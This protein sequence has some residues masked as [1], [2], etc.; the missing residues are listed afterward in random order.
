MNLKQIIKRKISPRGKNQDREGDTSRSRIQNVDTINENLTKKEKIWFKRYIIPFLK[1]ENKTELVMPFKKLNPIEKNF[2]EFKKKNYQESYPVFKDLFPIIIHP[3]TLLMAFTKLLKNNVRVSVGIDIK[4]VDDYSI[5]KLINLHQRLKASSYKPQFKKKEWIPQIGNSNPLQLSIE[6]YIVQESIYIVLE[7]IYEPMFQKQNPVGGFRKASRDALKKIYHYSK[8]HIYAIE[9]N[10]TYNNIHNARLLQKL[11]KN[12]YDKKLLNLINQLLKAKIFQ[13]F[14]KKDIFTEM[15]FGHRL[16]QLLFNIFMLSF[17][18]YIENAIQPL[19][20]RINTKQK[21]TFSNVKTNKILYQIQKNNSLLKK[22]ENRD[23]TDVNKQKK[24]VL[25]MKKKFR[26][27]KSNT[28]MGITPKPLGYGFNQ[29]INYVRSAGVWIIT[30]LGTSSITKLI[31]NKLDTFIKTHFEMPILSEKLFIHN[32][33]KNWACFLG[34]RIK[35][36]KEEKSILNDLI[37]TVDMSK[38]ILYLKNQKFL[39]RVK[40][41]KSFQQSTWARLSDYAILQL[42]IK[43][44][45]KIFKY[46]KGIVTITKELKWIYYILLT[47][48][49]KTLALKYKTHTINKV[50]QKYGTTLKVLHPNKEKYLQ[51]PTLLNLI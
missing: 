6:D 4:L 24:R 35:V 40:L 15:L 34:F 31:R 47:S 11:Q 18:E 43:T 42:Y 17:D 26:K 50:F 45:T 44:I 23:E 39:Q 37:I 16:T 33:Q 29:R 3:Q 8:G 48:C 13:A 19:I 36:Q 10:F 46:Y 28:Q 51:F 22:M 30:I 25:Q 2:K 9:G 21:R 5:K 7:K 49:A 12:I 41:N 1:L 38:I 20:Q 32:I 14:I 27:M